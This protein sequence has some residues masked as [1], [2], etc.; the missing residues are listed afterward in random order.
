VWH[1]HTQYNESNIVI[2]DCSL[3]TVKEIPKENVILT[4]PFIGKDQEDKW[5]INDLWRILN[6]FNKETDV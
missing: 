2:V 4:T 6:K 3:E 5:L 1:T